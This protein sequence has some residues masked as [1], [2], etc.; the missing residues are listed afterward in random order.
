MFCFVLF[1]FFSFF[2]F[3]NVKTDAHTHDRTGGSFFL[4]GRSETKSDDDFVL[5]STVVVVVVVVVA[6]VVVVGFGFQR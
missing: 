3:G 4:I 5:R 1:L 2:Y 6:V